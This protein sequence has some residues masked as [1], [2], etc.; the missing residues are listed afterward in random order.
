VALGSS[1]VRLALYA[2]EIGGIAGTS[3]DSGADAHFSSQ[4]RG[5][6]YSGSG[7]GGKFRGAGGFGVDRLSSSG[8]RS[9]RLV[10]SAPY[11]LVNKTGLRLAYHLTKSKRMLVE[12]AAASGSDPS[13][14]A[15][16]QSNFGGRR[17]GAEAGATTTALR[18]DGAASANSATGGLGDSDTLP[19]SHFHG[20]PPRRRYD[21]ETNSEDGLGSDC[22]PP[23][24]PLL[25]ACDAA[26]RLVV[27]VRPYGHQSTV[28]GRCAAIR[29]PAIRGLLSAGRGPGRAP[30]APWGPGRA[31]DAFSAIGC[32]APF[33]LD[34]LGSAGE[35]SFGGGGVLGCSIVPA[36]P[37]FE[38]VSSCVAVCPRYVVIN[39]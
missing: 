19:D 11:W 4:K 2:D 3:D 9:A 1:S 18:G 15:W 25:L 35:M 17:T 31:S 12:P 39:R 28:G 38:L 24:L 30:D 27:Q 5:G 16:A 32:S 23:P 33:A 34:A 21:S 6:G 36:P 22:A 10:L 20:A 29:A 8:S 37:G 13:T 7:I 26:E 14:G